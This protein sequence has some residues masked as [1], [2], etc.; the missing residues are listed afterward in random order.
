M[1]DT[2][3][4]M[5]LVYVVDDDASMRRSLVRLLTLSNW[6]VRA[7]ETAEEFLTEARESPNSFSGCLLLDVRL[8]GMSGLDLMRLLS[9]ADRRL[10]TIVMTGSFDEDSESESLQ[11]GASRFLNKPFS[12]QL[13]LQ[14]A[15]RPW[16]RLAIPRRT[17][18]VQRKK[19][20]ACAPPF[21][22]CTGVVR[23]CRSTVARLFCG[24][25]ASSPV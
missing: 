16:R 4:P 24:S 18:G 3:A 13:L 25:R 17:G 8:P 22:L 9:D 2:R 1:N 20:E 15:H 6:P 21:R 19:G 5:R 14:A 10:P 23:Y 7:F 12:S 11:L